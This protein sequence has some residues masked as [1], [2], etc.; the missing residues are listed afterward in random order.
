M[1]AR[2]EPTLITNLGGIVLAGGA[3]RRFGRAKAGV[4]VGGRT[5]VERAV[6]LLR[7]H[8]GPIVVVGR[9]E[10][11][12]PALD[13]PVHFDRPG[14]DAPLNA[15]A[16]GLAALEAADVL[17][18]ACDLPC[19]GPVVDRLAAVAP[20][21][22]AAAREHGGGRW[23]PLCARYPR[24]ATLGACDSL[25][26]GGELRL[27]RLIDALAPLAVDATRDELANVN[28]PAD[29]ARIDAVT[30]RSRPDAC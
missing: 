27:L 25:L 13:V 20:G 19:A 22:A 17:V 6:D 24:R 3:G 10:V 26:A 15:L 9:P 5:L 21:T 28:S 2:W 16:T 23:Q 30:R 4:V 18:L 7:P 12:L 11:A 14:P 1:K 29:L 8:C